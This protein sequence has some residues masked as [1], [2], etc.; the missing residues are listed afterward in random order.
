MAYIGWRTVKNE[1]RVREVNYSSSCSHI[2]SLVEHFVF[3]LSL[4]IYLFNYS[5]IFSFYISFF[6]LLLNGGLFIT[7][8]HSPFF[9]KVAWCRGS[10]RDFGSRDPS[11][12]LGVTT[13]LASEGTHFIFIR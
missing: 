5:N 11:S 9:C 2:Y 6:F 13:F 7:L 1:C 12:N 4:F 10:I 8:P 3:L